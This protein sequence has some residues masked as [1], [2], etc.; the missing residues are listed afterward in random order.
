M[1]TLESPSVLQVDETGMLPITQKQSR[2]PIAFFRKVVPL[3][4]QLSSGYRAVTVDANSAALRGAFRSYEH[5]ALSAGAATK[6]KQGNA[7]IIEMAAPRELRQIRMSAPQANR[8]LEIYR[9]D[10]SV[11]S[12]KPTATAVFNGNTAQLPAGEHIFKDTRFAVMV[13]STLGEDAYVPLETQDV[14]EVRIGAL[15]TGPRIGVG[16]PGADTASALFWQVPGEVSATSGISGAVDAGPEMARAIETYLGDILKRLADAGASFPEVLEAAL[17]IESD[18]PCLLEVTDFRLT[19]RPV[20][21][22]RLALGTSGDDP[23]TRDDLGENGKVVLRYSGEEILSKDIAVSIPKNAAI[24]AATV[25]TAESFRACAMDTA[26]DAKTLLEELSGKTTGIYLETDKWAAV[27]ATPTALPTLSGLLL[28]MMSVTAAA[29]LLVELQ[30]DWNGMPS[31]KVIANGII[32]LR[33]ASRRYWPGIRFPNPVVSL[34]PLW[35]LV[36]ATTGNAVWLADPG[37]APVSIL[38]K[39]S[40]NSTYQIIHQIDACRPVHIFTSASVKSVATSTLTLS[41]GKRNAPV[42]R[43]SDER[44]TFDIAAAVEG[45][46]ADHQSDDG[47]EIPVPLTFTSGMTGLVTVYPPEIVY[48]LP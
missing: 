46:L 4:F 39:R 11:L 37:D 45:Y 16:E 30:E 21:A 34:Q 18:A 40:I 24:A 47:E 43:Q 35:I 25:R 33:G 42:N 13:K 32:D 44:K 2:P 31:G 23:K 6:T 19:G 20:L 10:G 27:R 41:I 38:R 36:T 17:F 1:P 5:D 8:L 15:P 12:S 7:V 28:G 29:N 3:A 14:E 48:D 22:P 26:S 9:L